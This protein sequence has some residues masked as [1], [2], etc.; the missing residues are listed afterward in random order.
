MGRNCF[1]IL[2]V[3]LKIKHARIC[4]QQLH[5]EVCIKHDCVN[6]TRETMRHFRTPCISN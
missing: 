6:V 5:S 4:D 3:S 2:P 1:E